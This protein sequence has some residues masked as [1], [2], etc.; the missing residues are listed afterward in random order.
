MKKFNVWDGMGLALMIK[1]G[2]I[3]GIITSE[4]TELV[5]QRAQKL[6]IEEVHQG[7]WDKL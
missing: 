3:V 6:K 4:K 1:A 5:S 7:V 2:F